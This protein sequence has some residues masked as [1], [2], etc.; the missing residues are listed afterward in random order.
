MYL[1][2][3]FLA[4][5]C[6]FINY[7][8]D[9][10]IISAGVL[11][12]LYWGIN[13]LLGSLGLFEVPT[14]TDRVYLIILIGILFFNIGTLIPRKVAIRWIASKADYNI[15]FLLLRFIFIV[16]FIYLWIFDIAVIGI[17][18]SGIEF[19][20]IR[21]YYL[22]NIFKNF[23]G[24]YE[25]AYFLRLCLINPLLFTYITVVF[26]YI[27]VENEIKWKMFIGA[28]MLTVME[29][30]AFGDRL[31]IF[32]WI[33]CAMVSYGYIKIKIQSNEKTR[34]RLRRV[35]VLA[36]VA[37]PAVVLIRGGNF[38]TVLRS[39]YTYFVGSLPF[40]DYRLNDFG[41]L[42]Y[43]FASFQ[44][45][46]RPIAAVF[47]LFGIEFH[48]FELA[49]EFL[50]TNQNTVL[51]MGS[52]G[53]TANTFNYFI[54]CFGFFL[55]DGGYIGVAI[56]SF[57]WGLFSMSI[58]NRYVNEKGNLLVT[59]LYIM[60]VFSI[61]IGMMDF[62]MVEATFACCIYYIPFVIRQREI[63]DESITRIS[64]KV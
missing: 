38:T 41:D 42:T 26:S 17:I 52:Y 39:T 4:A 48:S 10:T 51:S 60:V 13:V 32:F 61:M 56:F 18:R 22:G 35:M 16:I 57:L 43:G 49:D 58:Y 55:K 3:V 29:Y 40:L 30:F 28:I 31:I 21:Y 46:I 14:A 24:G 63:R 27:C 47:K 11:F 50:N 54:N 36:V 44:G 5:L 23:W 33:S 15:N 8:N 64:V 37:I 34:N 12:N 2:C 53:G 62:A 1:M 7:V 59:A 6:G 9:K 19:G 45:I 25:V 20:K